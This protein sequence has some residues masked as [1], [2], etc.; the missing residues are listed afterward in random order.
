MARH[1]GRLL[2]PVEYWYEDQPRGDAP[3]RDALSANGNLRHI[4]ANY[5]ELSRT[6]TL[7]RGVGILGGC[8]ALSFFTYGLFPGSWNAWTVWDIA[9]S[10]ASLGLVALAVFCVRLDITVP[11]DT[12]VRFNR[13][14]GKIYAYEYAW[15]ANP[16]VRWPHSI[17]VFDWA[18]THAEITR[19]AGKSVRYALFLSHCKPGTLEVVD[20][21]QLGGQTIDEADMRRLWDYCRAYMEHG[22]ANLPAQ[23]PRLDDVNFRRSF[24]FFMPF[25]DPSAEGAAYRQRMHVI[26]WLASLAFMLPMFWLLLPLGL[27]RYLALRLAPRPRWPAELDAQ[28]RGAPLAAA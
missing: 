11:S 24:F 1:Q 4:D 19:Q 26:E 16:F 12:P 3:P 5:L 10:I 18:D 15:K 28:S 14:R 23:T 2:P 8:F 20:R 22:P 6:E 13:A 9:L 25:I 21:I 7:V 27:M 17:K